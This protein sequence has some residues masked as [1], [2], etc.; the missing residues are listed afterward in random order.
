MKKGQ[1]KRNRASQVNLKWKKQPVQQYWY[2]F[3]S[4]TYERL[5][6]LGIIK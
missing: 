1:V 6:A 5:K 3:D 4:S 2:Y